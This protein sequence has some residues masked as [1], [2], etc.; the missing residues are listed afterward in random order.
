VAIHDYVPGSWKLSDSQT[1]YLNDKGYDNDKIEA[2]IQR[3][4]DLLAA[5]NYKPPTIEYDS[6]CPIC[7]SFQMVTS[8]TCKTCHACGYAGSCG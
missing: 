7:G 5:K 8:G 3:M 4:E 6:Q 1:K 2:T